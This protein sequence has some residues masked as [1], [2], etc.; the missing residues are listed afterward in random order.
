M[1]ERRRKKMGEG[2]EWAERG[3]DTYPYNV[4]GKW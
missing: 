4:V 1:G 3:I 2:G